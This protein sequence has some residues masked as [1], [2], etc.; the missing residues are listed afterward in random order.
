[1]Y[2][3]GCECDRSTWYFLVENFREDI[4]HGTRACV[5]KINN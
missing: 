3:S 4:P 2:H 5:E 1:M